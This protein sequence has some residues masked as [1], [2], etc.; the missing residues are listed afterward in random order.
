MQYNNMGLD[1]SLRNLSPTLA[2]FK[3]YNKK[4]KLTLRAMSTTSVVS[5][6]FY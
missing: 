4:I 1:D 6:P 2:G 5:S 3:S